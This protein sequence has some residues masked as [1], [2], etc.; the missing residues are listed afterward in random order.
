MTL[1]Q[2]LR[3][4]AAVLIAALITLIL[5][6]LPTGYEGAVIYQGADRVAARVIAVNNES[7]IDTGLI[8]SGEQTCTVEL[9]GGRFK[10]QVVEGV[11]ML[12]GSLEAGQNL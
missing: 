11:N 10:G 8:R 1:L 7:I 4:H 5:L 12:N 6:L 2:K 3:P 9:L